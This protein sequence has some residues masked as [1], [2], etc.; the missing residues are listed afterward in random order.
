MNLG[1]IY[2][3]LKNYDKSLEL[4]QKSLDIVVKHYGDKHFK[5]CDILINIGNVFKNC[6]K[7]DH[8]IYKY[9]EALV[10]LE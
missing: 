5:S 8:A 7:F 9:N 2:N 10:I 4:L 3:L 1:N 6:S